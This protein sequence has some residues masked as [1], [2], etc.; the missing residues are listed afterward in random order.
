L[1]AISIR[2]ADNCHQ[3][4]DVFS[5]S[6]VFFNARH[7]LLYNRQR[8]GIAELGVALK[9]GRHRLRVENVV[10]IRE[11]DLEILMQEVLILLVVLAKVN[12]K[13]V[14]QPLNFLNSHIIIAAV[15]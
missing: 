5:A 12:K 7:K 1:L 4:L 13:Y 6:A 10:N 9:N 2:I 15:A 3:K 8:H 11:K 14:R